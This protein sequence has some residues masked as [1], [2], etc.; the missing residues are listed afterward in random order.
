MVDSPKHRWQT[1][2]G[3]LKNPL[4]PSDV[5]FYL[6]KVTV[7]TRMEAAKQ[8]NETDHCRQVQEFY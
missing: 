5:F 8:R 6:R 3:K 4:Y 2:S 7:I 1:L